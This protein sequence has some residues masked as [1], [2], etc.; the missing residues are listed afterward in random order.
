MLPSPS[1]VCV[2]GTTLQTTTEL[3]VAHLLLLLTV[4]SLC[5]FKVTGK[6]VYAAGQ[7]TSV[8]VTSLLT[9]KPQDPASQPQV[10]FQTEYL[11]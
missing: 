6:N 4:S 7:W 11:H 3:P 1:S 2:K 8:A 5:G 10:S 9:T